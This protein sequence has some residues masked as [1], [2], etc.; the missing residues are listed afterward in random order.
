MAAGPVV[1]LEISA[2][3]EPDTGELQWV[4]GLAGLQ[5]EFKANTGC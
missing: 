1:G 3:W 4:Q 5:N 2:T